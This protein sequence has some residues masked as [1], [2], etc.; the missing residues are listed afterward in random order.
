MPIK[1]NTHLLSH[2]SFN[3]VLLDSR[4][5][6]CN[7]QRRRELVLV[8]EGPLGPPTTILRCCICTFFMRS[9]RC[10]RIR[11]RSKHKG[12]YFMPQS[13][14]AITG[15]HPSRLKHTSH[16]AISSPLEK[17]KSRGFQTSAPIALE[18]LLAI[19]PR[20]TWPFRLALDG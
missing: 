15:L 16:L 3:R 17:N 7:L 5:G 13:S 2:C 20:S 1:T 18:L 11:I 12:T 9:D 19:I 4:K 14:Q 8:R 6:A 10:C